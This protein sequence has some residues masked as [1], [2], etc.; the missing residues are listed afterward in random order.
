MESSILLKQE[1]SIAT[2][3]ERTQH[4]KFLK[5]MQFSLINSVYA[6]RC[7]ALYKSQLFIQSH[8]S[9]RISQIECCT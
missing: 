1:I 3:S 2:T 6:V 8:H 9:M 7:T 4:Q 5:E